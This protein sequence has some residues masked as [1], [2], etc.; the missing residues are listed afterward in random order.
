MCTDTAPDSKRT[1]SL[2]A[3]G[4]I[5]HHCPSASNGTSG[6]ESSQFLNIARSVANDTHIALTESSEYPVRHAYERRS[7]TDA[8]PGAPSLGLCG[9]DGV[10]GSVIRSIVACH[11]R[12]K[13]SRDSNDT[14]RTMIESRGATVHACLSEEQPRRSGTNPKLSARIFQGVSY[15]VSRFLCLMCR[16][17]VGKSEEEERLPLLLLALR[18]F[19]PQSRQE[20]TSPVIL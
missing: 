6:F 5:R 12:D 15:N 18:L 20:T 16:M 11:P 3:H 9:S 10:D 2:M 8:H 14:I 1:I 17:G 7:R 4:I 13:H 19:S